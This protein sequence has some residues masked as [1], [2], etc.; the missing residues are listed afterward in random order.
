MLQKTQRDTRF[1]ARN[2]ILFKSEQDCNFTRTY[3][4]T[5]AGQRIGGK[6]FN[7][8][9]KLPVT[10]IYIPNFPA[11]ET[12]EKLKNILSIKTTVTNVR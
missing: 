9:R 8:K 3:G 2:S 12:A 7:Y 5:V 10:N 11:T 1:R 4:F 6:T